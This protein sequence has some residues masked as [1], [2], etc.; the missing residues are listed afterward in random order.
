MWRVL[1]ALSVL[2]LGSSLVANASSTQYEARV[3]WL[4]KAVAINSAGQVIGSHSELLPDNTVSSTPIIWSASSGITSLAFGGRVLG[5][6][7]VNSSGRVAAVSWV[8]PNIGLHA[9]VIDQNGYFLDLDSDA[10]DIR[11]SA[12]AINDLGQTAGITEGVAMFWDANGD[13]TYLGYVSGYTAFSIAYGINKTGYVVGYSSKSGETTHGQTSVPFIWSQ[14]KGMVSLGSLGGLYNNEAA[15]V[16]D[17][18]QVVGTSTVDDGM[19]FHAFLW[20]ETTGM[21]DLG[22]GLPRSYA[23]AINNRGQV[24]GAVGDYLL[25]THAALWDTDGSVID[26]GV[27]PGDDYSYAYGINDAGQIVGYS[28]SNTTGM[29]HAVLWEPIPEPSSIFVLVCGLSI[30]AATRRTRT[31]RK[32]TRR[33]KL[34]VKNRLIF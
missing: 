17:V 25:T 5:V 6:H 7:A 30:L 8:P 4:G 20:T 10:T 19:S 26:L 2:V 11:S 27:L 21:I 3:L 14:D 28:T 33:P 9:S 29:S 16:N 23:Y 31:D 18:G 34:R 1:S 12:Y 15:D 24:V 13:R 22:A 32:I